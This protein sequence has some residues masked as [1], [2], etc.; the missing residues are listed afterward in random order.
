MFFMEIIAN[1]FNNHTKPINELCEENLKVGVTFSSHCSLTSKHNYLE[2]VLRKM[3]ACTRQIE[4]LKLSLKR[5]VKAQREALD[6][7]GG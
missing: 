2:N 1:Y 5:S 4:K 6:G 7:V 3:V